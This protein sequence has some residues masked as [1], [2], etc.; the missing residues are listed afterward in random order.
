M[1]DEPTLSPAAFG[2]IFRAFLEESVKGQEAEEAPFVRLLSEHLGADPSALPIVTEG[3]SIIEH[4]NVQAAFDV[5]VSG[6]G[7]S[8][9]LLGVTAEQKRYA[10]IGLSDLVA[11]VR[12]G[13]ISENWSRNPAPSI[14]RTSQLDGSG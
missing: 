7:R 14:T 1:N 5:W 12:G 9:E 8:V 2:R 11:P 6:E 3:V 4:P 10:G 13:L